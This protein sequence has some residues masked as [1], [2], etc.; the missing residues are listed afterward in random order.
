MAEDNTRTQP[1]QASPADGG[2]QTFGAPDGTGTFTPRA[3][4]DAQPAPVVPGYEMLE[5]VGS[6]GMGRVFKARQLATNRVVAVKLIL[7]GEFA[8]AVARD[9]FK[10][11]IETTAQLSHPHIVQLYEAGEADGRAFLSCEFVAGGS[12]AARLD[13]T[14]WEAKRAARLLV[15][16]TRAVAYAHGVAIVHRDLKPANI[17]LTADGTP[18]VADF[19]LAKQ[20]ESDSHTHTGAILGTPSYMPPE[21]AGSA[22]LVGPWSDVYSLGAIFYELLTGR[23]PFKGADFVETLDLVRTQE[24]VPPHV[25]SPKL[26][27]DAE[28]ICLKCLQKDPAKRYASANDLAADLERFLEGRPIVARP[29][30]NFERAWRWCRRNPAVASLLAAVVLVSV[31]GAVIASVLAEEA[32][33]YARTANK[34]AEE[35]QRREKEANDERKNAEDAREK[36]EELL[37]AAQIFQAHVAAVEYRTDRLVQLLD[38]TKPQPGRP[39]RRGWEWH[40]LKRLTRSWDSEQ[41]LDFT[42]PGF[43]PFDSKKEGL[44]WSFSADGKRALVSAMPHNQNEPNARRVCA[45]A[46]LFD[47]TTGRLIREVPEL[48][49]PPDVLGCFVWGASRDLRFVPVTE[50]Y[51]RELPLP[52]GVVGPPQQVTRY[53]VRLVNLEQGGAEVPFPEFELP[54]VAHVATGGNRVI[55]FSS[56]EMA[57]AYTG[58]GGYPADW[59]KHDGRIEV[60]DRGQAGPARLQIRPGG[61]VRDVYVRAVSPDGALVAVWYTESPAKGKTDTPVNRVELWDIAGQPVRRGAS[62]TV[63]YGVYIDATFSA[64]GLTLAVGEDGRTISVHETR[65]GARVGRWERPPGLSGQVHWPIPVPDERLFVPCQNGLIVAQRIGDVLP[66]AIGRPTPAPAGPDDVGAW[67]SVVLRPLPFGD[68]WGFSE[69]RPDDGGRLVSGDRTGIFRAWN[70]NRFPGHAGLWPEKIRLGGEIATAYPGSRGRA[71]L[72]APMDFPNEP[73]TKAV[74]VGVYDPR[75]RAMATEFDLDEQVVV[76]GSLTS[77]GRRMLL[78]I[79]GK[80]SGDRWSLRAVDAPTR[81]LA[82]GPGSALASLSEDGRW[83]VVG[84]IP[85]FLGGTPQQRPTVTVYRAADGHLAREVQ[86]E[87][88]ESTVP[89]ARVAPGGTL[90]ILTHPAMKP[91][92]AGKRPDPVKFTLRLYDLETGG[93][94]GIWELPV[95]SPMIS[96]YGSPESPVEPALFF[97]PDGRR[98]GLSQVADDGAVRVWVVNTATGALE[99]E[100]AAPAPAVRNPLSDT[101]WAPGKCE[102]GPG[103]RLAVWADRDVVTWAGP[104]SS[105]VRLTGHDQGS[106]IAFSSDGRRV[107]TLDFSPDNNQQTLRAWELSA[108]REL[109]TVRMADGSEFGAPTPG[110][111]WLE[112]D[113][114]HVVTPTGV[115]VFDG[116]PLKE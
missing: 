33:S 45:R 3:A 41:K 79:Q 13:G 53:R 96:R 86:F 23:P 30:G 1:P 6:G 103:G 32:T 27:R 46:G 54:P 109:L 19:G 21:Q 60:W 105:P 106:G 31:V 72:Y 100:Y 62:H 49:T 38:E 69:T 114:L 111:M 16:L 88:E 35:A 58:P 14:P 43:A 77:D 84:P 80:Q 17:L 93:A 99:A 68:W 70:L 94:R 108:G 24:P 37:Y 2:T 20:L 90:A 36:T 51:R 102:F 42:S 76:N 39:D 83:V 28:T 71:V 73:R 34:N 98:A 101:G 81:E 7:A 26:P 97:S 95:P 67:R 92:A 44:L 65:T 115:R 112:G 50:A 22:R 18:K 15:P 113:R 10:I 4:P 75:R 89:T 66:S 47:T 61:E 5:P 11:E 85:M 63:G 104:G 74:R 87:I 25:L 91:P 110:E 82:G 29:V 40:Y 56:P 9:R 57:A 107:F 64:D 48:I 59:S 78:T 55:V 12:L 8:T 52:P 116:T